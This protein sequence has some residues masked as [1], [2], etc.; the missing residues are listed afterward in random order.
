MNIALILRLAPW[1]LV[2]LAIGWALVERSDYYGC[3]AARAGDKAAAEEMARTMAELDAINTR[4]L[5][6]KANAEKELIRQEARNREDAINRA[7]NSNVCGASQ[8][9]RALFDGVRERQRARS[10]EPRNP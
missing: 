1:A 5:Q 3:V 8:P 6:A 4:E 2:A 9:F 7:A 10:G